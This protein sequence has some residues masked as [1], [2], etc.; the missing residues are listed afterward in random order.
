MLKGNPNQLCLCVSLRD[1]G[2]LLRFMIKDHNTFRVFKFDRMDFL[3]V[4]H[5]CRSGSHNVAAW[6]AFL[7][8]ETYTSILCQLLLKG[9]WTFA[10]ETFKHIYLLF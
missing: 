8:K 3:V 5:S 1:R 4:F 9:M 6:K 7:A 10:Q 2:Q